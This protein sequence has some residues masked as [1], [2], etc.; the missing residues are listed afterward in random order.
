[1]K[2][3]ATKACLQ[4]PVR[5]RLLGSPRLCI[6][7]R[8]WSTGREKRE[9]ITA[10]MAVLVMMTDHDEDDEDDED[11]DLDDGDSCCALN[12]TGFLLINQDPVTALIL[13]FVPA[14]MP[15]AHDRA[16]TQTK[17]SG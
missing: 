14:V 8:S 16:R 11:D 12:V 17:G 10:M 9:L 2:P 6:D 7:D 13:G 15:A 4:L 3:Q 5:L 1:M